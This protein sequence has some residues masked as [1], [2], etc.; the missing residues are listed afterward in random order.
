MTRTTYIAD[1]QDALDSL[2]A[3]ATV[4]P[5]LEAE[6]DK[7]LTAV[8]ELLTPKST[9]SAVFKRLQGNA[10]RDVLEKMFK[11]SAGYTDLT[12]EVKIKEYVKD[13]FKSYME[14]PTTSKEALD[15]FNAAYSD[16][17]VPPTDGVAD[18]EEAAAA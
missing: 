5:K 12:R 15:L 10:L 11:K 2:R 1:V 6:F 3:A 7:K 13:R 9:V 4:N 14:N 8:V 16:A 17:T 18:N